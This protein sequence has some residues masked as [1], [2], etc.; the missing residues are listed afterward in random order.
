MQVQRCR[1]AEVQ[2]CRGAV[3]CSSSTVVQRC[4]GD[5]EEGRG[6][7]EVIRGDAE[8]VQRGLPQHTAVA[9]M[10]SRCKG[11]RCKGGGAEV[12]LVLNVQRGCRGSAEE[13]VQRWRWRWRWR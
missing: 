5:A 7:A 4:R 2:R 11:E 12:V 1:F 10:Q 13:A 9:D 8:V 3:V 6:D